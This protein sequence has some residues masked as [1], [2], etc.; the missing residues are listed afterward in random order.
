[1]KIARLGSAGP[2]QLSLWAAGPIKQTN[3]QHASS[4]DADA[5]H[6]AHSLIC[7]YPLN[8]KDKKGRERGGGTRSALSI[9]FDRFND[10][11]DY[12]LKL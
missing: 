5:L 2:V 7:L 12:K 10:E 4:A 6:A 9:R 1:M 11:D 3:Y 8:R